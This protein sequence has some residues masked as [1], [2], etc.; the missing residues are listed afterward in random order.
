MADRFAV[1]PLLIPM[2]RTLHVSLAAV[3][4][5]ASLYY[6]AYGLLP[7]LYGVLSDRFGRV[8][9]MRM[10][11]AGTAAADVLSAISPNLAFLLA[12]RFLTG[13]IACGV[14]PTTLVYIG[15]RVPFNVRQQAI[16]RVL[17]F[18]AL[19]TAGGT[20]AAGLTANYLNWRLFF[21][22][23]A[24]IAALVA[25]GLGRV[26]ESLPTRST[27]SPVRQ[28]VLILGNRWALLVLVLGLLVGAVMFGFATYFAPS[29]EARGETAG[30]AGT[31][32]ATYGIS[33]LIC[34]RLFGAVARRIAIPVILAGGATML[35][36]AYVIASAL[37]TLPTILLASV[38][39]GGAY[40]FMQSTFQTW[41]TDIVPEARGT[42]TALFATT[43]F[44]GAALATAAVAG[45]ASA[46][47]Y[48]LLFAIAAAATIPVL[49][50]GT[51]GRW[52][53]AGS[54]DVA[55]PAGQIG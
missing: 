6:L 40:A 52:R 8:R 33:V 31:V 23:P 17:T 19:G 7:P 14:F 10:A 41:A 18:V 37:Q 48:A 42:S 38:L 27:Q 32:V 30:V 13:A 53:Y 11:L 55:G 35:V 45:L 46:H 12:A 49:I 1:A 28:V 24:V 54:R 15:D 44:T 29:L 43:I 47:Q 5:A 16:A 9:V 22:F 50:G 39:T 25:L 34:T 21:I 20:L 26:P 4:G 3:S 36:L 51:L 2:A